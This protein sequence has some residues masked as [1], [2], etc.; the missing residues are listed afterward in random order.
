MSDSA[1]NDDGPGRR[2]ANARP[3]RRDAGKIARRARISL[4]SHGSRRLTFCRME[5]PQDGPSETRKGRGSCLDHSGDGSA[6]TQF[7]AACELRYTRAIRYALHSADRMVR[8]PLTIRAG[9]F[10]W[11]RTR[12]RGYGSRCGSSPGRRRVGSEPARGCARVTPATGTALA[13]GLGSRS[14]VVVTVR[15]VSDWWSR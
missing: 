1:Y 12:C 8:G 2:L 5:R 10:R 9:R 4:V 6:R 7:A 13:G 11:R 15:C 14:G 3:R